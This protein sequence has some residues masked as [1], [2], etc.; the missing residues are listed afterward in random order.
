MLKP[1]ITNSF[2]NTLRE[3]MTAHPDYPVIVIDGYQHTGDSDKHPNLMISPDAHAANLNGGIYTGTPDVCILDILKCKPVCKSRFLYTDRQTLKSDLWFHYSDVVWK[4]FKN[5]E[6]GK[7]EPDWD[8][9]NTLVDE[10]MKKYE[11]YWIKAIV[12]NTRT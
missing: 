9:V 1:I 12:I 5:G 3:L 4:E 6:S 11:P 10:Q 7:D 2:A 8:R